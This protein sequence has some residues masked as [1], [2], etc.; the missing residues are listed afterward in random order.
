M[1]IAL[2]GL[3]S[4]GKSYFTQNI[5]Q[6]YGF[7]VFSKKKIIEDLCKEETGRDDWNEWH[8]E[9][10]EKNPEKITLKIL[11]KLPLTENIILDAVHSNF[12][13]DIIHKYFP[14][15]ILTL[16]TTFEVDRKER[17]NREINLDEADKKRI[18]FWHTTG[19]ENIC[20]LTKV[21]WAFNGSASLEQNE[22]SFIE[23]LEYIK[24]LKENQILKLVRRDINE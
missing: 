5:P 18:G 24:K 1:I 19:V 6:K 17:W 4:A 3:H 16:M 13:W 12:E 20:L 11:S 22:L 10:F 21:S 9:E 23:L 8:K 14:E 15:S 7:K 2:T